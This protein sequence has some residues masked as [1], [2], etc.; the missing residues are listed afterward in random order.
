MT[1][2]NFSAQYNTERT[3]RTSSH[4]LDLRPFDLK[5]YSALSPTAPK[6]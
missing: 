2:H 3:V 5:M 6:L 4:N 1:A